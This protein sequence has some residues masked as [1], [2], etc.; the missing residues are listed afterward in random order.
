MARRCGP[1]HGAAEEAFENV[2]AHAPFS[3]RIPEDD[4]RSVAFNASGSTSEKQKHL[5]DALLLLGAAIDIFEKDEEAK[6]ASIGSRSPVTTA[7]FV[8][9]ANR[10]DVVSS[11][12][13]ADQKPFKVRVRDQ[14]TGLRATNLE[15]T[16]SQGCQKAPPR[17]IGPLTAEE[18]RVRVDKWLKKRARMIARQ[19]ENGSKKRKTIGRYVGRTKFAMSRRR[20]KGRFVSLKFLNERGIKFDSG[21]KPQSGWVC[22]TL[23]GRVFAELEDALKAVDTH[24]DGVKKMKENQAEDASRKNENVSLDSSAKGSSAQDGLTPAE[25]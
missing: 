13:T 9:A 4:R 17:R 19:R 22:S 2:K 15:R 6:R 24:H 21:A 1:M 8:A 10:R 11:S 23:G 3:S 20:V 7:S 25:E 14:S 12:V 16:T 5:N 18:R